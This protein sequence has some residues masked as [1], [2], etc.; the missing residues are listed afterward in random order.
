MKAS[1]ASKKFAH[2]ALLLSL[3][4]PNDRPFIGNSRELREWPQRLGDGL[5]L[6]EV[7]VRQGAEWPVCYGIDSV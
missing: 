3:T 2:H 7:S 4:P 6:R 5:V 1:A